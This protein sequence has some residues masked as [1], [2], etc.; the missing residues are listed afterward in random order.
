MKFSIWCCCVSRYPYG[1]E[2]LAVCEDFDQVCTRKP[3]LATVDVE[4]AACSVL[5]NL[6]LYTV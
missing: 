3:V 2:E 6:G 1:H 5:F 4:G